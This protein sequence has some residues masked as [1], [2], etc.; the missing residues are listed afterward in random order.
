M[1]ELLELEQKEKMVKILFGIRALC[2]TI[3]AGA[4][5]Y[6]IYWSFKFYEMGFENEHDYASHLRPLF[7]KALAVT[8]VVI[9]IS[10]GLRSISDKLKKLIQDEIRNKPLE[11]DN[12]Q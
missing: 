4:T 8:A 3:A 2:W 10:F 7:Y 9:L 5:V 1:L 6:W 11:E 12:A